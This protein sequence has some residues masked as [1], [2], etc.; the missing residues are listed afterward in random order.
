LITL[1]IVIPTFCILYKINLGDKKM[2]FDVKEVSYKNE[3]T[4]NTIAGTLTLPCSQGPF[5]VVLLIV[6][7]VPNDCNENAY[8]KLNHF[9][10][11]AE[12]LTNKGIAVLRVDKR[13]VGQS[14]GKV[15]TTVTC[16]DLAEDVLAGI[17]YLKTCKEIDPNQIGLIG[18]SEVGLVA[19]LVTAESHDIAFVVLMSGTIKNDIEDAISQVATQLQFDRTPTE[20]IESEDQKKELDNFPWVLSPKNA[21][22]YIEFMNNAYYRSFISDDAMI[23]LTQIHVPLLAIYGELDFMKPNITFIYKTMEQAKNKDYTILEFPK[24]NHSL[25]TCQT[26]AI[27]KY[28]TIQEAIS[29][30]SL[31]AISDWILAIIKK[32]NNISHVWDQTIYINQELATKLIEEQFNLKISSIELLG[33]GFDNIAYIINNEF[34]FR[35]PRREIGVTC[36]QNEIALLP[37]I[38]KNVSFP[39][40][41]PQFIGKPSTLYSYVFAGYKMIKGNSLSDFNAELITD[42]NF[43][44]ILASWLKELH[45]IKFINEDYKLDLG[46]RFGHIDDKQRIEKC[47]VSIEKYESYFLDA[48]FKK[49]DLLKILE[50]LSKLNFEDIQKSF[51]IHGDL[52]SRHILVDNNLKPTGI[53]DWGD[54]H[55][56]NPGIDLS[57]GYMIFD[58]N[59][60]EV[61]LNEYG[62]ID[63][64]TKKLAIFRTFYHSIIILPYCYENNENKLK[65]WATASLKNAIKQISSNKEF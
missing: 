37:Y 38:K 39:F 7:A 58:N 57:I 21:D 36:M 12:H 49:Q 22:S 61:F 51:Y 60:L 46:D 56:G 1:S 29:Q 31:N 34:V 40:S 55:I 19:T 52:Y 14:T 32:T 2:K 35:F 48:S 18:H 33:E 4:G 6:G 10:I 5:P 43:A 54:I 3:T 25:Q 53:I 30:I 59:A 45:S 26:G 62:N 11:L 64:Q 42:I 27:T 41:Y 23:K 44:K 50:K 65:A 28:P 16:K 47:R 17:T 20:I 24:L 13:G 9:L 63:P 8:G 15:D